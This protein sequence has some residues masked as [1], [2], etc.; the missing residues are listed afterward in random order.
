MANEANQH[1]IAAGEGRRSSTEGRLPSLFH[2]GTQRAGSTYLNNLLRAHPEISLS[3]YQEVNY[4]TTNYERGVHWYTSSFERTGQ[5]I[6]TSPKYFLSGSIAAQRIRDAVGNQSPRFLLILRNPIDYVHSHYQLHLRSGYFYKHDAKYPEVP[7][8][9]VAFAKKYPQY[10]ERGSYC[11]LLKR[12]WLARF[13]LSQFKIVFFEEFVAG[14]NDVLPE[15]LEF[16]DLPHCRLAASSSTKNRML[17]S[18]LLYDLSTFVS[19]MPRLKSFLKKSSLFNK[20][21]ENYLSAQAPRLSEKDRGFL[22]G[23]FAADVSALKKKVGRGI[24]VWPEFT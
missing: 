15:I 18:P 19:G 5:R 11:E 9:L 22:A 17:R 7:T 24:A 21:Y 10:L 14:T 20:F 1:G 13:D 16:F 2:I 3:S 6:D 4:Y 23:Y 12:H 8:D